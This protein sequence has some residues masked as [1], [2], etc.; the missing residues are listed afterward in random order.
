MKTIFQFKE[1]QAMLAITEEEISK[2][3]DWDKLLTKGTVSP[4]NSEYSDQT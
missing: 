4:L 1:T 2:S 3:K